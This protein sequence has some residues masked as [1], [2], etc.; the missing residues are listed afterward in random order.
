MNVVVDGKALKEK[1]LNELAH[2]VSKKRLRPNLAIILV[3]EDEPSMR[4]IKQK[5]KAAE[6]IG[7]RVQLVQ[8]SQDVSQERLVTQI[9]QLNADK[10][11][12]GII[13]Q[14]PL[15]NHLDKVTVLQTIKKEKDVDGLT[16]GSLFKP[17]TPLGV[18]EILHEY[19]VPIKDKTAV[20]I[21]QSDLVGAPLS[22]MLEEEGAK[23]TRLDINTPP[24]I[25]PLVQQGDIVV[26]AVGQIGLVSSAMVK[27]GAVVI[28]VG[29]NVVSKKQQVT[30]NK[31]EK[32]PKLVGDV[33]FEK[34]KEKASLITPV[35]GG[36]GPMTV[37]FLM[38]N[39]VLAATIDK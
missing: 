14:L 5:Q 34:V 2:E 33:D 31:G 39:I 32:G 4:Y 26:S 25:A 35:P 7:A 8:L 36:V 28:D 37:A 15:P 1:I 22:A 24:P 6:Q 19:Q 38:K 17:A 11:V 3:G 12:T 21:G 9:K 18:M 20:V 29:M 16:A 27:P 13:V 30:S 10:N 23:V